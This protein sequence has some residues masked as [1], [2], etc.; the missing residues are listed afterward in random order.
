MKLGIASSVFVNYSIENT[1]DLVAA[2][3]YDGIDIWGGRPHVYRNDC[4]EK[5]LRALRKRLTDNNLQVASHM[6]AFFRYPHSLSNPN[7]IVRQ[8]SIDYMRQCIDNAVVLD[9]EIVLIV[10]GRSLED[11]NLKDARGR[12]VDSISQVCTWA[13][14]YYLRLGIEPANK[15]VTDLVVTS[16]DALEI[17]QELS[18]PNLG[19]VMDTGHIHL[20][21][22]APE[23]AIKNLGDRLF[24]FHV[25]DNDGF[26]Q[27]NLVPG[28]GSFD[29]TD[30][31]QLLE[32]A[33][34]DGFLSA[35]LGW[36]YTLDPVPAAQATLTRMK[37][38]L[39]RGE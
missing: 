7:E 10:P 21:G 14:Q 27:Q 3:G 8:D 5:R 23:Q 15:M 24:Q 34:Y 17:I 39:Y 13:E 31:L 2:A 26:N 18:Y 16:N 20:T 25:N 35:E 9:A 22:E 19:V 28:E 4:D 11:Q 30:F 38:Y 37:E 32:A 12:L 36:H 33:D 6:P 1:I 29:F